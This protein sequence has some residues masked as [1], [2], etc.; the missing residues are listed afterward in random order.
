MFFA[1]VM[2]FRDRMILFL[3]TVRF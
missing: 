2:F 1:F 3:P